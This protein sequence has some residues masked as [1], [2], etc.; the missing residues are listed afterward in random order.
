MYYLCQCSQRRRA[1]YFA[2]LAKTSQKI[3]IPYCGQSIERPL[4]SFQADKAQRVKASI[5]AAK[6]NPISEAKGYELSN[7]YIELLICAAEDSYNEYATTILNNMNAEIVARDL[8]YL[9]GII[10]VRVYNKYKSGLI[11]NISRDENIIYIEKV[12]LLPIN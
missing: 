2:R 9:P 8:E 12:W 11:E 6:N 3:E 1:L 5:A 7:E 4:D 10:R